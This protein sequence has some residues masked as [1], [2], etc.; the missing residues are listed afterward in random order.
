MSSE[1]RYL[2]AHLPVFR[3]ERCGWAPDQLVVLAD[4]ERSALR[5]QAASPA[6]GAAG[7]RH[8]MTVTEARAIC[9]A[10]QIERRVCTATNRGEAPT[11]ATARG[12]SA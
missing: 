4:E 11:S 5:V 8:G 2:V 3:L 9:P 12:H 1:R 6:A 7:I 10:V